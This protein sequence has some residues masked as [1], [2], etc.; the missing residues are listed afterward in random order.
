MWRIIT[1]ILLYRYSEQPLDGFLERPI[2][3]TPCVLKK[4]TNR[5]PAQSCHVITEIIHNKI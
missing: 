3:K 2:L 4:P 5:I 1:L